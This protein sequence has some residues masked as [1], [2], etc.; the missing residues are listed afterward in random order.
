MEDYIWVH[1]EV[2]VRDISTSKILAT[3]LRRTR[4]QGD[5][6]QESRRQESRRQESRALGSLLVPFEAPY[7]PPETS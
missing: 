2:E 5:R 6:R 3:A 4:L 7:I 1:V